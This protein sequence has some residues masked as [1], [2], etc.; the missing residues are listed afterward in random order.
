MIVAEK[1]TGCH[2]AKRKENPTIRAVI[3][4]LQLQWQLNGR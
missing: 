2:S 1:K 3:V 4:E